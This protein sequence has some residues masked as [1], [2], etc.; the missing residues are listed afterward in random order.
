MCV[1]I[2]IYIYI[3]ICLYCWLSAWLGPSSTVSV[4][5]FGEVNAGWV[6]VI[7]MARSLLPNNIFDQ[8]IYFVVMF[9]CIRLC[10]TEIGLF[11]HDLGFQMEIFEQ[12]LVLEVLF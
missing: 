9:F 4:V 7:L 12:L 6:L 2:Y 10:F 3:L 1:Y 8:S 5:D 11:L